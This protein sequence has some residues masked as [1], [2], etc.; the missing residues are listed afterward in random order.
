M[1]FS[2]FA[3]D[4]MTMICKLDLDMYLDTQNEVPSLSGSKVVVWTDRRT[5][6]AEI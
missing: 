3:L 6:S 2:S 1:M 4:P 5:D